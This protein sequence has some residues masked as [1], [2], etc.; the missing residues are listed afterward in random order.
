M[1]ASAPR[2]RAVVLGDDEAFVQLATAFLESVVGCTVDFGQADGDAFGFV[3]R[4][5]PDVVILDVAMGGRGAG[6]A[7]L[8]QLKADPDLATIPVVLCLGGADSPEDGAPFLDRYE[9]RAIPKPSATFY[10]FVN[11][12][13]AA[14]TERGSET[15]V[16]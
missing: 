6:W 7:V 4:R 2:P 5:R 1:P 15:V 3:K 9:V 14:L 11:T 10:E 12:V 13:R 16:T 8:D